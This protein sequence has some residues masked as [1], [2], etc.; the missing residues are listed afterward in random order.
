ME[1]KLRTL[2]NIYI[3]DISG[4]IDL[5]NYYKLKDMIKEMIAKKIKKYIINFEN[6]SYIDSSGIGSLIF[7]HT[8]L[9][10]ANCDL[11]LCNIH[12]PVKRVIE[13]TKLIGFLPIVEN[14]QDAVKKIS[15]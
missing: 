5:Y 11:I 4:E 2:N 12:G 13:L 7:I 9:K 15:K 6:V 8:F 10:D 14:L 1:I 3:L